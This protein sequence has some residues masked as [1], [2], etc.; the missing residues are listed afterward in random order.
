MDFV[1]LIKTNKN[2]L[3]QLVLHLN[4]L[5]LLDLLELLELLDLLEQLDLYLK[6]PPLFFIF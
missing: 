3:Y 4:L 1:L 2:T 6:I 5:D